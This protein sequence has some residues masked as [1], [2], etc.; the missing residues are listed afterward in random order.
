MTTKTQNWLR[1]VRNPQ[2]FIVYLRNMYIRHVTTKVRFYLRLR[3]ACR[4]CSCS[5]AFVTSVQQQWANMEVDHFPWYLFSIDA[6]SWWNRS[7]CSSLTM[8]QLSERNQS[9]NEAC[10]SLMTHCNQVCDTL[11]CPQSVPW[12]FLPSYSRGSYLTPDE[13]RPKL[14][15]VK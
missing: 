7:P 4:L 8:T 10:V 12:S 15:L 9:G 2:T 5:G 3:F 1:I 6:I 13:T 14:F 11:T